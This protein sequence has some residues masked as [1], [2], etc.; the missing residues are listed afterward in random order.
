MPHHVYLRGNNRRR[1]FSSALDYQWLLYCLAGGL[2]TSECDLHQLTLMTNHLHMVVTPP[3]ITSL[4]TLLQRTNQRYAQIRNKVRGGSGKLFEERY[5]SKVIATEDY[6]CAVTL[7]NDANAYRAGI[8][9]DPFAH[10]WSTVGLHGAM[11]KVCRIPAELW[12]PSSWYHSLGPDPGERASQ[13][14][15]LM[16][17]YLGARAPRPDGAPDD[18]GMTTPYGRRLQRPDGTSAREHG[19]E[20]LDHLDGP[21]T[22]PLR[23]D[24]LKKR[25]GSS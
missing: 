17:H 20:P 11:P 18:S 13:Y 23:Y 12:T 25:S 16:Y 2:E 1:L 14:R 19:G 7:Y 10:P 9:G 15:V 6:L 24:R 4:R 3:Q 8:V 21:E 22:V 5:E